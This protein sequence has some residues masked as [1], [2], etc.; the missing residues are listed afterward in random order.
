MAL[1]SAA[2]INAVQ[3][4]VSETVP[5]P[6][7]GGEVIIKAMTG[8]ERDEFEAEMWKS[9][10]LDRRNYRSRFLVRVLV[11]ESGTR[12]YTDAGAA[13]LGKRNAAVIERLYDHAGRM[14]GLGDEVQEET[15]GNSGT[16][17]T[18]GGSDSP[19]SSPANSGE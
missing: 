11:N 18:E 15:E 16:D 2:D 7:W 6:E 4:A 8:T 17:G 12:I 3:D 1:L 13:D 19:S 9:G 14:S 10:K 5:V